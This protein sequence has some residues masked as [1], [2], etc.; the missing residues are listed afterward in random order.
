MKMDDI[1]RVLKRLGVDVSVSEVKEVYSEVKKK[2][3]G[4]YG[5]VLCVVREIL[6]KNGV[7][8]PARMVCTAIS[9]IMGYELKYLLRQ[10][11]MLKR[12]GLIKWYTLDDYLKNES[13]SVRQ[14]VK[15]L[16]KHT[17]ITSLALATAKYIGGGVT[18]REVSEMYGVSETA[19]RKLLKKW[20]G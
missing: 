5:K 14:I 4:V 18:Q 1:V 17:N 20:K 11:K 12:Q 2:N 19:I 9:D 15:E 16:M 13:E 8:L 3:L 6:D 7:I 10:E